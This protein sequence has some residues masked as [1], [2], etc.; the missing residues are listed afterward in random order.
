VQNFVPTL[1]LSTLKTYEVVF[2]QQTAL[3]YLSV[4]HELPKT[5]CWMH[6]ELADGSAT[7][8]YT[9]VEES[10]RVLLLTLS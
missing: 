6:S 5:H 1:W 7:S 2:A 3:P 10:V 8:I 9:W 4:H